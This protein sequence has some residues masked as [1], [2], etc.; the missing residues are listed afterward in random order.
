M[1]YFA[2]MILF[3]NGYLYTGCTGKLRNRIREHW[4]KGN[5]PKVIWKQGFPSREEASKREHQIKG[6][7]R[8][9]KLALASGD[10]TSLS[11][12]STRRAGLPPPKPLPTI[13]HSYESLA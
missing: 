5:Q 9:K 11:K 2:Y 13:P 4:R 6:W 12:L 1:R 7:T 3:D 8:A 10:L